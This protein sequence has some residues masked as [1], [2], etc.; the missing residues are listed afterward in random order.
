ME[1][2]VA[3]YVESAWGMASRR[4]LWSV[5]KVGMLSEQKRGLGR[6]KTVQHNVNLI[7]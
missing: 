5:T 4:S 1:L 7:A 6:I 2:A 3:S